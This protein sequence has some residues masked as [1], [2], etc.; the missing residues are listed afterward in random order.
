MKNIDFLPARYR[1]G[2]AARAA[3]VKRWT[4]VLG[5]SV[6]ITPLAIY[7]YLIHASVVHSFVLVEP[8]FMQAQAKSQYMTR[9]EADLELARG[10]AALLTW[11]NHPWPR[12]QVLAQVHSRLP[13]SVRL[14]G[15]RLTKESKALASGQQGGRNRAARRAAESEVDAAAATRP[16]AE[17][18]LLR[19]HDQLAQHDT[20]V[21]LTGVTYSTTELHTYVA[22]L[23]ATTLFSKSELRSVESQ[24]GQELS[25]A[26]TFEIRLV[27]SPGHGMLPTSPI[28]ANAEAIADSSSTGLTIAR[29]P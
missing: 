14:T 21:T 15:V 25:K 22:L 24:P 16:A 1:E 10:E 6:I 20:I 28:A 17:K 12:T 13:Q 26:Q 3:V 8:E 19:L 5:I 11:L 2:Y 27:L 23:R 4:L 29:R 9:L 7:Q 18:D